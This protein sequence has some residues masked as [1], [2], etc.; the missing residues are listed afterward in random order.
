MMVSKVT[1]H[2]NFLATK[3]TNQAPKRVQ[4]FQALIRDLSCALKRPKRKSWRTRNADL[5]VS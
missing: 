4:Q 5:T 1:F 3:Q 2:P